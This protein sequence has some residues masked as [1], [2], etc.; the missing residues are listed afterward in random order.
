MISD[1][2]KTAM[3][4]AGLFLT[5]AGIACG[6]GGGYI[7][8]G[9]RATGGVVGFEPVATGHVRILDE[10]L[11]IRA[12][13]DSATVEVRYLMRNMTDKRVRVRFGFPIEE[14][15]ADS[16]Y[17]AV[18]DPAPASHKSPLYCKN[19]QIA[20]RGKPLRVRWQAEENPEGDRRFNGL[21]GWNISEITFAKGEEVPVTIRF[22]S[23]YPGG[24]HFVSETSTTSAGIFRYRLSTAACWHGTIAEGRVII[25]P[26]GIDPADI[27][28]IKPVNRFKREGD[29]WIWNFKDLEPTLD[30]D[31]EIE[32][33]PEVNVFGEQPLVREGRERLPMH[34][35][36]EFIDR[37]GRW[38][39][40]HSNYTARA[41]STL[42]PQGETRYDANNI[43][44]RWAA[45]PWSEG[46]PGHGA[47]EWLEITPA[48][49]KPLIDIRIRPGYQGREDDEMHL[50]K[51]NARPKRVRMELNG[52]H[53]FDVELLD[54]A[55]EVV[56]PVRGYDKPVRKIRM[57]FTEVYPGERHED[58][59]VTS[60]RLHA[61]LDREPKLRP[62]R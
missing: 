56:I 7:T 51:A 53:K 22:E 4:W 46:A 31:L 21:S 3:Y 11:V 57:T 59:C 27:R 25:E 19:Y 55:D 52:E 18:G 12:G 33:R 40:L 50:F 13:R 44:D 47:G 61:R 43:R 14:S 26:D 10:T 54:E 42:A 2:H 5:G 49:A 9:V 15:S 60:V 6:N 30:D 36:A 8:G 29:R 23:E 1:M 39:M 35:Y 62:T 37:G 20:A 38:S 16:P 41:S 58:L 45:R 28:V 17:R 32:C 48:A 34:L 24:H